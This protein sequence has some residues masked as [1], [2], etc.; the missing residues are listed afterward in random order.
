MSNKDAELTEMNEEK[1]RIFASRVKEL[2]EERKISQEVLGSYFGVTGNAIG[3]YERAFR[4]PDFRIIT[5]YAEFFDVSID[6]LF[7]KT[8]VR[9]PLYRVACFS[10]ITEKDFG[11]LSKGAQQDIKKFIEYVMA[12]ENEKK[13]SKK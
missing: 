11:S 13:N 5:A 9:K 7:G 10:D 1:L 3:T 4:I 6:Y 2:R 8:D 12:R